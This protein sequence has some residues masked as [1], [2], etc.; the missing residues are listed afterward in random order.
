MQKQR[1]NVYDIHAEK[2]KLKKNVHN[3]STINIE[4]VTAVRKIPLLHK[5]INIPTA[6]TKLINIVN[7]DGTL[8]VH[9]PDAVIIHNN[10][11]YFLASDIFNTILLLPS[12]HEHFKY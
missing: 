1:I 11:K 3:N 10:S 5:K 12:T 8:I 9:T 6:K 4:K 2:S 7:E